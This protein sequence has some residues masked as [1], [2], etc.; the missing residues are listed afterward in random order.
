MRLCW[1]IAFFIGSFMATSAMEVQ[2]SHAVFHGKNK[3]AYTEIYMWI[4][5]W[6]LL[7]KEQSNKNLQ[8]NIELTLLLK[9]DSNNITYD[10]FNLNSRNLKDS[11]DLNFAIVDL[12]RYE[13]KPGKYSVQLQAKDLNNP[14]DLSNFIFD[15]IIVDELTPLSCSFSDINLVDTFY[16]NTANNSFV[17]NEMF[18]QPLVIDFY[19]NKNNKLNFYTE[20]YQIDKK[21]IATDKFLIK[22]II[23]DLDMK[24][25]NGYT[26]YKKVAPQDIVPILQ[27]INI[28]KLATGNYYLFVEA[29]DK[30]NQPLAA[31]KIFF[32]RLNLNIAD[33]INISSYNNAN[34]FGKGFLDTASLT[35]L[36]FSVLSLTPIAP[37]GDITY[38]QELAKSQSKEFI[39]QYL[40]KF[41]KSRDLLSPEFAWKKYE[42]QVMLVERIYSTTIEHGFQTDRG[43]VFLKYGI[44]SN[45]TKNKESASY[46]YEIWQY[47]SLKDGQTNVRFVFYNPTMLNNNMQLLHS[48]ARGETSDP[49]WKVKI[50]GTSNPNSLMDID[51]NSYQKHTGSQLDRAIDGF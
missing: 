42:E 51:N 31:Q 30:N 38:I 40:T 28:T 8:V 1:L 37:F 46:D 21:V 6:N 11:N 32:Q 16:A 36:H 18:M 26:F 35:Y 47:Y 34:E 48:T 25:V 4:P 13:L 33:T 19:D 2:L 23:K 24:D 44:P 3:Q 27:S 9:K 12:K 49:Q 29:Y 22:T 17:K 15:D 5:A 10:K 43:R 50:Y 20:L 45:V 39:I 14:S 7:P 41:W